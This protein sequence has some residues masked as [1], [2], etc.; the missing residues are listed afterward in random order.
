MTSTAALTQVSAAA[1]TTATV[2]DANDDF[3]RTTETTTVMTCYHGSDEGTFPKACDYQEI[4][5]EL[6][7]IGGK[8]GTAEYDSFHINFK[9]KHKILLQDSIFLNTALLT[10][11]TCFGRVMDR[12][13]ILLLLNGSYNEYCFWEFIQNI[14][15]PLPHLIEKRMINSFVTFTQIKVLSMF[16]AVQHH[17]FVIV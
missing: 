17:H 3:N 11:P 1:T 2:D 16:Y 5:D 9:T 14:G 8:Q 4:L 10:L 7:I 6:I 13:N 12:R 15:T